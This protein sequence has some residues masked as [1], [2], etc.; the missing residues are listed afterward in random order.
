MM[1]QVPASVDSNS[2]M[3]L[4]EENILTQVEPLIVNHPV[5]RWWLIEDIVKERKV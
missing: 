3:H 2:W 5:F 4:P 1:G